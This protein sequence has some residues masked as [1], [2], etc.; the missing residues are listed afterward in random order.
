MNALGVAGALAFVIGFAALFA[1]NVD[2][3]SL[4][5]DS[6]TFSSNPQATVVLP[7][8]YF[9]EG[10]PLSY[11]TAFFFVFIGSIL[12][13]GFS[14]PL[15]MFLEGAKYGY[16]YSQGTLSYYDPFYIVPEM[17][18]MYAAVLLGQGVLKDFEGKENV[19]EQWDA[20]KKYFLFAVAGLVILLV[21]RAFIPA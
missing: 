10:R 7:P 18:A 9:K 21:A 11:A 17:F 6:F 4:N 5:A 20:A 14:A 15:V 13:F 3:Q 12:L 1:L 19:F 2:L 8:Y 16:M